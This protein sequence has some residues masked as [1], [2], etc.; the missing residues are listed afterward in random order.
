MRSRDATLPASAKRKRWLNIWYFGAGNNADHTEK[1]RDLTWTWKSP[2]A[3]PERLENASLGSARTDLIKYASN[4]SIAQ[5]S[6]E[7]HGGRSFFLASFLSFDVN[8]RKLTGLWRT[9]LSDA[10]S[11]ARAWR[12][13]RCASWKRSA[14]G[15]LSWCP[16]PFAPA[17]ARPRA[18]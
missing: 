16:S 9:A 14:E 7:Q 15:S 10:A 3:S 12:R 18:I 17:W 1:I 4:E 5:I 2:V 6:C 13:I 8:R 11:L